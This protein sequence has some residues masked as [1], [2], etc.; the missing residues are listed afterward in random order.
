M[1][2]IAWQPGCNAFTVIATDGC[3]AV[4][5]GVIATYYSNFSCNTNAITESL[6]LT[7]MGP[8]ITAQIVGSNGSNCFVITD[9]SF[10]VYT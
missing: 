6:W 8:A 3:N 9:I 1:V 10:V 2:V 4:L 5:L 7:N